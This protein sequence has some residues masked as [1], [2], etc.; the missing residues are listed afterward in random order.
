MRE[1]QNTQSLELGFRGRI[2]EGDASVELLRA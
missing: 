2:V 1:F